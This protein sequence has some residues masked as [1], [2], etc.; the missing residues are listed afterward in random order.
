MSM[1]TPSPRTATP[2]LMPEMAS[3]VGAE[4]I[5]V[6]G[7]RIVPE[8]AAAIT[9]IQREAFVRSGNVHD[10]VDNLTGVVFELDGAYRASSASQRAPSWEMLVV[11]ISVMG[12][13]RLPRML[14][15]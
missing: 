5:P 7:E 12:L 6:A 9:A 2:R 15:L 1:K 13:K 14:P 11:L 8:L 3:P 4:I 10:A